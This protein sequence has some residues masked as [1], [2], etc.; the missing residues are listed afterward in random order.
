M[1]RHSVFDWR[2]GYWVATQRAGYFNAHPAG[3]G[4]PR[5]FVIL[6]HDRD[7]PVQVED[8]ALDTDAG[9]GL[10]RQQKHCRRL[11]FDSLIDVADKAFK[12]RN[13]LDNVFDY[14]A[15]TAKQRAALWGEG[16]EE[17]LEARA[18]ELDTHKNAVLTVGTDKVHATIVAA[19][20]AS[21]SGDIIEVY[22]GGVANVYTEVVALGVK[23]ISVCGMLPGQGI[24]LTHASSVV[25]VGATNG[26][27]ENF[28]IIN[29]NGNHGIFGNATGSRCYARRCRLEQTGVA[30]TSTGFASASSSPGGMFI[31][32]SVIIGFGT[33]VGTTSSTRYA[34]AL[35]CTVVKCGTGITGGATG[36]I[37]V[38]G[39]LCAGNSVADYGTFCFGNWN[40][41]GDL[42]APGSA[43]VTGFLTTDFA[44]YAGNGLRLRVAVAATTLA[45][46]LGYPLTDV[47][48]PCRPRPRRGYIFAGA[49][50]D[51]V[52]P[53]WGGGEVSG[54]N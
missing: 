32:N 21:A 3:E 8:V 51:F 18:A 19:I 54:V 24:T 7:L 38:D 20:A 25:T 1:T 9:R 34:S 45:R 6:E 22:A 46:I 14:E 39:N 35:N 40:V 15:M 53:T 10:D 52:P 5:L 43:P 31:E 27:I 42:S 11:V 26:F 2:T 48:V 47:D 41:S 28:T 23:A 44:D 30:G 49:Y 17:D 36:G 33:G 4:D 13:K 50:H 12:T 16:T 29:S 37:Y